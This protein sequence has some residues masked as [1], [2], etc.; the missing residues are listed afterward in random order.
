MFS[1]NNAFNHGPYLDIRKDSNILSQHLYPNK[2][3]QKPPKSMQELGNHP[4]KRKNTY[5][6]YKVSVSFS[7]RSILDSNQGPSD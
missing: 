4:P 6:F 5:P 3:K 1:I 7:V 2:F